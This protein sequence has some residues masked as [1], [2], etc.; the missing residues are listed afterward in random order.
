MSFGSFWKKVGSGLAKGGA[1]AV[2]HPEFLKIVED[3]A[4]R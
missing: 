1:W 3:L 4:K 2:G